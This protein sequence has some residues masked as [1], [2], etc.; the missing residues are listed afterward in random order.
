MKRQHVWVGMGISF[1]LLVYLFSRIEYDQLWISLMSANPAFLLLAG[2]LLV[3]TLAIRAW[4]WRYL[5]MPLKPVGFPSLMSATSI[6]MMANMILPARLGELVRAVVLGHREQVDKSASFATVVVERLLD[7]FT[8][9]FILAVLLLLA[10][11]PTGQDMERALQW[12]RW[13]GLVFLLVYLGVFAL[14]FHLYRSTTHALQSMRRICAW[15][16]VRWVDKLCQLLEAFSGGL[17]MLGERQSLVQII[18][19]SALLWGTF[20]VHNFSVVLAFQL[21]LPLTVGFLLVVFQ[22]F[23]VMVPSSPGFVGTHHAASVACL[24]L[25]SVNPGVALSVALVMHALGF[26]LTVAIGGF[27]LWAAGL[28]LRD[29]TRTGTIFPRSPSS[30]E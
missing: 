22:A 23:A 9:L 27:Y 16:P 21:P 4:R 28:S 26:F 13:G 11:L 1:A 6:G 20:G 10:P 12:A 7:G 5:L 15:L 24:T 19:G 17:K 18:A 14:L 25:W 30:L 8:I 29:L 2:V 3:G